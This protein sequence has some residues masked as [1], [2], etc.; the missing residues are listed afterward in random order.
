[1]SAA[2]GHLNVVEISVPVVSA[3]VVEENI[4]NFVF[5]VS[6]GELD[7]TDIAL[8]QPPRR[9]LLDSIYDSIKPQKRSQVLSLPLSHPLVRNDAG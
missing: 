6:D 9:T 8:G 2:L 1:L 5:V 3:E 7:K 4:K